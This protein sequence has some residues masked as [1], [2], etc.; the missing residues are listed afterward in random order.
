M[1]SQKNNLENGQ[2][3]KK[4][5]LKENLSENIAT[6][7]ELLPIGESFDLVTRELYLGKTPA[8]FLC[9]N[10]FCKTEVLQQIFSD[11]QNPFYMQD[12]TVKDITRYVNAKIGYAQASLCDNWEDIL[13]NVLCGPSALFIDGFSQAILLDVRSY[14]ARGISEPD[15]ERITK[16]SRDGFVETLLSNAN[17]IRRRIRS[18]HLTFSMHNVGTESRTDVAVAYIGNQVNQSL[19]ETLFHTLDTLQVSSLTMGT[20]SLEELLVKKRWW[21]PLPSIRTT[22]RP[23]VACS[24]LLEGHILLIVD[25][26]PE[27]LI[28]PCTIF[29]FTQSPEDYYKSPLIGSYF[30]LVRFACIPVSLLLMPLFLLLTAYYPQ[31][32]DRWQI[33]STENLTSLQLIFY[34]LAVEFLLDLFKYS[35]S[36]SSSRFSGSLSIV[37]GLLIGDIAVSLN[38]AS[39]EVLFYAAITLLTSLSLSSIEFADALRVYRIFLILGTSFFGLWGFLASLALVLIS[40]LATPTFGGMSYFWPLFPFNKK[41]LCTLLFRYPTFK[42]Q[43]CNVWN[44]GKVHS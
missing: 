7:K 23:D 4:Q 19:L 28:L 8:Y 34:V 22:E 13:H 5:P 24:Y 18:P 30:R 43:P 21:T 44:R 27:V 40:I 10:G 17:L 9:I 15:N 12:N 1:K 32:A 14:P 26:S 42:A 11:L 20:K 41:A 33:L 39:T 2:I 38:W 16:G 37:G 35:A 31:V 3:V 29:Q 25:N 6:L 36:V